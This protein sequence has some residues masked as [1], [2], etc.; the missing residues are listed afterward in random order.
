MA[1][2]RQ[3]YPRKWFWI[4]IAWLKWC[5]WWSDPAQLSQIVDRFEQLDKKWQYTVLCYACVI[6]ACQ[7]LESNNY[8][9]WF[10]KKSHIQYTKINYYTHSG[11]HGKQIKG[12]PLTIKILLSFLFSFVLSYHRGFSYLHLGVACTKHSVEI[13]I[14][15]SDII[16]DIMFDSN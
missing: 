11:L 12:R 4:H 1:S 5:V 16:H 13:K 9:N 2:N 14:D 7:K 6:K 3:A 10:K 8:K 15:C